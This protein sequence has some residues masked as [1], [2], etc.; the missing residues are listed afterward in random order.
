MAA[1][2]VG[3]ALTMATRLTAQAPASADAPAF[4]VVSIKPN[5][6]GSGRSNLD[7]QP[8]GRFI[9]VNVALLGLVRVAYGDDGR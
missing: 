4:T 8:G 2:A 5:T 1:L 3:I 7:L 9:A 6:S